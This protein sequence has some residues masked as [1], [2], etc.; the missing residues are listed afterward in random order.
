M[1]PFFDIS[2][3][4]VVNEVDSF[5]LKNLGQRRIYASLGKRIRGDWGA[6]DQYES[7]HFYTDVTTEDYDNQFVSRLL[8]TRPSYK[9]DKLINHHLQFYLSLHPDNKE[10]F[11]K[12]MRYEIFPLLK[13]RSTNSAYV[14][15]FEKWIN[16]QNMDSEK[17]NQAQTINNTINVRNVN[18]PLQFQQGSDHSVQTQH[19]HPVSNDELKSFFEILRKDIQQFDEDIRKDF[20][21]EMD[22]ALSQLKQGRDV[23]TQISNISR[24]IKDVGIGTFSNLLAA[25]IFE[26]VKPL[27]G[28]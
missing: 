27:L 17:H 28:L 5:Q 11:L 1:N 2:T 13:K 25:P 16:N 20:S 12:H 6:S 22:Y 14:E 23:K 3:E 10:E 7:S 21:M 19:N 26:V 9:I 18:A 8:K 15:L 24:L 4:N